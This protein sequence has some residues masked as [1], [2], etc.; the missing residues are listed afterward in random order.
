MKKLI[1]LALL[2]SSITFSQ[3][4]A[5]IKKKVVK[6]K[7]KTS[8]NCWRSVNNSPNI[9][10]TLGTKCVS[11]TSVNISYT[12]T[13]SYKIKVAFYI[14]DENGDTNNNRPYIASLNPDKKT[15]HFTCKANGKYDVLVKKYSN[16]KC[17]FPN[18]NELT[19]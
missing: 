11:N 12:N 19:N 5:N 15:Y 3:N 9:K 2:T 13:Y 1:F 8:K 16:S 14:Y 7:I 18:S 6:T 4:I 17:R 10:T